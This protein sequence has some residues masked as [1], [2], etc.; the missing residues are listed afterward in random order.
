MQT[1]LLLSG[2]FLSF[3]FVKINAQTDTIPPDFTIKGMAIGIS[4]PE[5]ID[6]MMVT[7]P[8]LGSNAKAMM[9]E[10]SIKTYLMT[11]R[12]V[13]ERGT[14]TTYILSACMEFYANFSKNYKVNL[15]PDFVAINLVKE[16]QPDLKNGLRFLVTDGTVSAD[17]MP[18]D[19][20]NL[21]RNANNTDKFRI[22]NY[23]QIFKETHRETQKVFEVQKALMRGN[24]VIVEMK[25]PRSFQKVANTRFWSAIGSTADQVTL[26]FMVVG[27][28][29]E[30][31]AFEIVSSWGTEWGTNGY[32]W[33]DFDD[34]GEIAQN[35]FVLVPTP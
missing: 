15:S 26:P 12:K 19:S 23:L 9:N 7:M 18:Y 13:G 20:P 11:P 30:L 1:R 21:P 28:N 27:Y 10:Q 4:A 31:E 16:G 32:L 33:I 14:I 5:M 24:P 34:F 22:A 3:F 29:L 2:I 35:G 17:L 8:G 25:V 6:Q